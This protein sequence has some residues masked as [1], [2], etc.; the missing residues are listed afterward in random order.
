[1]QIAYRGQ[2]GMGG[3]VEIVNK[4]ETREADSALNYKFIICNQMARGTA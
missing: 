3:V 2:M 1:M 4:S